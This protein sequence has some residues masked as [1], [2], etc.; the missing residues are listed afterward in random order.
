MDDQ[1]RA[2]ALSA[3]ALYLTES[4]LSMNWLGKIEYE[5]LREELVDVY[6]AASGEKWNINPTDDE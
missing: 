2:A 3:N 5:K 1:E 4:I 6:E